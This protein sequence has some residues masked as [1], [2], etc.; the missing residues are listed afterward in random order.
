MNKQLLIDKLNHIAVELDEKLVWI[1]NHADFLLD[2][3]NRILEIVEKLEKEKD[4]D[5]S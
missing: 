4:A 2:E 1:K 3:K 5:I